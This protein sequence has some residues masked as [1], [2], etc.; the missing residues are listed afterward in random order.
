MVYFTPNLQSTMP[1]SEIHTFLLR[2]I[3]LK[4]HHKKISLK[5]G[6]S[7]AKSMQCNSALENGLST[8]YK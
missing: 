2:N 4:N 8:L 6:Y 7:N 5:N 1:G 3:I